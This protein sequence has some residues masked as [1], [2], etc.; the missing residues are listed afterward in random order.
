MS[1]LVILLHRTECQI[2][3]TLTW[4]IKDLNTLYIFCSNYVTVVN[5]P[6]L[7]LISSFVPCNNASWGI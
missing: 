5:N 2:I 4:N 7:S 1:E 6:V 3:G